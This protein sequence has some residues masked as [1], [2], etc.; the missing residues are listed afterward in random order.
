[1]VA[2]LAISLA[3]LG[4]VIRRLLF[5]GFGTVE[6][7]QWNLAKSTLREGKVRLREATRLAQAN[8]LVH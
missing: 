1:M 8:H 2:G 4:S 5:R 3:C 7:L 6:S